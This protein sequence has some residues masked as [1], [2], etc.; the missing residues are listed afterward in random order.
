M[1][2]RKNLFNWVG[3]GMLGGIAFDHWF[4]LLK[5]NRFAVDPQ[6]WWRATIITLGAL[7]NSVARRR[8][9]AAFGEQVRN[10]VVEPPLFVLGLWRSG[11][12]HLQ[13]LFAVD[14]RFAFP[15]WFQVTRPH[16]FLS[17]SLGSKASAFESW[18]VSRQR[19]QD[20]MEF[21]YHLP[22]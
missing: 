16:R 6:Y 9:E 17:L 14:E 19:I 18:L 4:A 13:N 20:G 11:T 3:P 8:E 1:S 10:T 15:N 22:A 12:T 2:W 21:G 5:E 7:R